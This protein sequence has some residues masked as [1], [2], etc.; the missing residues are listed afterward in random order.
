MKEYIEKV[1]QRIGVSWRYKKV[2]EE[3]KKFDWH[4]HEEYEIAIHRNFNGLSL[5]GNYCSDID[6]NHMVLLAPSIPHAF[7]S[8]KLPI[9]QRCETHV[10][11]FK[12][13]WIEQLIYC[14]SELK[15]LR[16]VLSEAQKGIQFSQTTAEQVFLLLD[17]VLLLNPVEQLATL[18]RVFS[19]L[20]D[21][22]QQTPLLLRKTAQGDSDNHV[23]NKLRKAETF[24]LKNF[25]RPIYQADLAR[26]LY[27]SESTIRRFF[28]KHYK[29]S[30]SQHLM[31]IRLN[32]ACELLV[33]TQL[34]INIIMEKVGYFNQANFN[35]Q[36]KAYKHVTP[37]SYRKALKLLDDGK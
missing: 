5:I 34:P 3:V 21:D 36:F 29:E 4:Q 9:S 14:C 1:P 26:H 31:K 37:N 16:S 23:E 20:I 18:M 6:H 8:D 22:E 33:N 15:P 27:V 25:Q 2:L 32:V 19:L 13:E 35:R 28:F 24:L 12:K 30:F 11:W 17:D 10:L 7:C